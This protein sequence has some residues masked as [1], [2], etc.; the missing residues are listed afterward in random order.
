MQLTHSDIIMFNCTGEEGTMG[1]SSYRYLT[2]DEMKS[3]ADDSFHMDVTR[4]EHMDFSMDRECMCISF[5]F[6]NLIH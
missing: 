2:M 5:L 4:D 1:D 6:F 3:L